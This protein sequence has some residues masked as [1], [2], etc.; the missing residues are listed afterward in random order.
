[1]LE[2]GSAISRKFTLRSHNE[3]KR[4]IEQDLGI[5]IVLSSCGSRDQQIDFALT[6]LLDLMVAWIGEL[7]VKLHAGMFL[8]KSPRDRWHQPVQH[9]IAA[10]QPHFPPLRPS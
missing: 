4:L 8:G 3:H 9:A 7:Y 2:T 1:M 6:Q 5:E 10:S